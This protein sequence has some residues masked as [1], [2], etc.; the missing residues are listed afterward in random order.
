MAHGG[1]D[2]KVRKMWK[3]YFEDLYNI[4][5]EKEVAVHIQKGNYFTGEA[6]GIAGVEVR[7]GKLKIRMV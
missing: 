1:G 7:V 6:I 4:N 3:E 5:T 2:D